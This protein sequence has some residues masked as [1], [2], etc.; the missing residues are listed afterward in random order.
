MQRGERLME[1]ES[2]G[3][4]ETLIMISQMIKFLMLI[5]ITDDYKSM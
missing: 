4:I 2:T 1:I 3:K 5:M